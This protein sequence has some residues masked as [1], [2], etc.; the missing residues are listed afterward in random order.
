MCIYTCADL[1]QTQ[2][3]NYNAENGKYYNNQ[4]NDRESLNICR[5]FAQ[6]PGQSSYFSRTIMVRLR[7][8]FCTCKDC[9]F[10]FAYSV[11]P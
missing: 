11:H 2:V 1:G 3:S 6:L 8:M 5:S 10:F 7:A 9:S 4:Y